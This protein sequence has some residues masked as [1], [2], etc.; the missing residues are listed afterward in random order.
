MYNE[1]EIIKD[2][3][4]KRKDLEAELTRVN[5][6]I[7]ALEPN[8][9]QYMEWKEKALECLNGSKC[10]LQTLEILNCLFFDKIAVLEDEIKRKRYVT[11][12]S[13]ALNDLCKNNLIKK[14]HIYRIKGDFYGFPTWFKENGALKIEHFSRKLTM[15][16]IDPE[17]IEIVDKAA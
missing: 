1:S 15:M 11:G 6:A 8:P 4:K 17:T 16:N 12:L 2:L 9:I 14:F 13:V 10:Y 3:K 7:F 5:K